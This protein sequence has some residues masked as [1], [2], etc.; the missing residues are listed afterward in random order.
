LYGGGRGGSEW[1]EFNGRGLVE[2]SPSNVPSTTAV[3]E[4]CGAGFCTR[5]LGVYV[6]AMFPSSTVLSV[7]V[8]CDACTASV[9]ARVCGYESSSDETNH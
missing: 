9:E 1:M 3:P 8:L 2:D 7:E 4:K 6:Y 5:A